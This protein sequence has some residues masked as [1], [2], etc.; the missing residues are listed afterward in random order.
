MTGNDREGKYR[1]SLTQ[2]FKLIV[3]TLKPKPL[4]H[5]K[6][7]SFKSLKIINSF[8]YVY[9]VNSAF[10]TLSLFLSGEFSGKEGGRTGE[11]DS[12]ER[13]SQVQAEAGEHTA[14]TQVQSESMLGF[15]NIIQIFALMSHCW[16]VVNNSV[17]TAHWKSNTA[18]ILCCVNWICVCDV[19]IMSGFMSWRSSWKT[20]R[21]EQN[22]IC[23]RGWD[24]IERPTARWRETWLHRQSCWPTGEK[25]TY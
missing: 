10:S 5:P 24:D 15:R 2:D 6:H 13:W 4:G 17:F 18:H 14:S 1:Q 25:Q 3:S 8:D 16:K 21:H 20:R 11:W 9:T 23:R 12:D 19:F 22:K 7:S